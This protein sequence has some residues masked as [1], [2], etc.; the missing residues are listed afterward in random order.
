MEKNQ[1][2]LNFPKE[3]LI[4]DGDKTKNTTFEEVSKSAPLIGIYFSAHWCPPC[5][6]FTPQLVSFYNS[7]NKTKKE[8]EIIF[9]SSDQAEEEFKTYY[10]EMP[11][12]AVPYESEAREDLSD[13][14]QVVGIPTLLVFDNEGHLLDSNGKGA[15]VGS[16]LAALQAWQAK[17]K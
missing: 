13:I 9:V 16:G 1:H 4:K 8:I 2:F 3:L 5:R 14:F 12:A 11:W 10:G 15:V 7:V 17:K 6:M